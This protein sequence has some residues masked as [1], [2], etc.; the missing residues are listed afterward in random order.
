MS[1]KKQVPELWVAW[2]E[3]DEDDQ[4][5]VTFDLDVAREKAEEWY[6]DDS[7]HTIHLGV[8]APRETLDPRDDDVLPWRK[9]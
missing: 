7:Y 4:A 5:F 6:G 8:I 3:G 2:I 1:K 9:A